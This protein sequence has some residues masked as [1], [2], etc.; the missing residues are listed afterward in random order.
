MEVRSRNFLR[1]CSLKVYETLSRSLAQRMEWAKLKVVIGDG[2]VWIWNPSNQHFSGAIQIVNLYHARQHLWEVAAL[3]PNDP[4]AQKSWM[5][6]M[7]ELLD[8]GE[9]ERRV[10]RLREIAA[11]HA[12]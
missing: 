3:L 2:A 4:A 10:A 8:H 12:A 1:R 9:I 7:K 6:P 11:E 5:V